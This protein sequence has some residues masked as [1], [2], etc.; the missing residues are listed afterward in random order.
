[1]KIVA[2]GGGEIGKP[3]Y[4]IETEAIDRE[5]I[6]LAGKKH[7]KVLFLPT[8]SGDSLSYWETFKK[9]YGQ[10]LEC[11]PDVLYLISNN[12][13]LREIKEKILGADIIY[14][15]GGNTLKMLRIWRR[16]GVDKVLKE[17]GRKGVILSGLSA[18]AICWFRY[19]NSDSRKFG[20]KKSN[21]LIKV[22]G[23]GFLPS[24][25]C[26]HY[27]VE[28]SRRYSLKKMI[29]NCGGVSIALENCSALEVIDG[30]YRVITSSDSAEAYKVYKRRRSNN[31]ISTINYFQS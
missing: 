26:P 7:P 17:A 8:A 3:G 18:G 6:R 25:A 16:R 27:D 23:I 24:M 14:V 21:K 22:S 20:S 1:M 4:P 9:Y 31:S 10:K 2:I 13:S 5:I 29:Q 11:K 30:R 28:K 12:V 15:G 19:G